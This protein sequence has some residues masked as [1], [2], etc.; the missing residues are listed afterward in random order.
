METQT[1]TE[2]SVLDGVGTGGKLIFLGSAAAVVSLVLP[3]LTPSNSGNGF[4]EAE[5]LSGLD[6]ISGSVFF[7]PAATIAL[8]GGACLMTLYRADSE[9]ARVIETS[10][11]VTVLLIGLV[12]FFSPGTALGGGVA[13][14]LLGSLVSPGLGVYA[15]LDAGAMIAAGGLYGYYR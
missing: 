9:N 11:G 1:N 15:T 13:G 4:G 3:W 7:S 14:N 6:M 2:N 8:A 5:A 10:M 12:L